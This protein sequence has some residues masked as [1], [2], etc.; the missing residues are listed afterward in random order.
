MK[1]QVFPTD[2]STTG[3]GIPIDLQK[4]I[5]NFIKQHNTAKIIKVAFAVIMGDKGT[6]RQS[7]TQ[8]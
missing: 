8:S 5:W 1:L 3:F 2:L 6:H 4:I 7:S